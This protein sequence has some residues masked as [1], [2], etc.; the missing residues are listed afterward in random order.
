MLRKFIMDDTPYT[1]EETERRMDAAVRKALSTPPQPR[2]G[3][4][5]ESKGGQPTGPTPKQRK[6]PKRGEI[7]GSAP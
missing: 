7:G 3:K 2:H 1:D 5:K 4:G 6:R